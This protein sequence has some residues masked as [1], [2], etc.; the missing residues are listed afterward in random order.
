MILQAH[1][2]IVAKSRLHDFF[3]SEI[4][5]LMMFYKCVT[6]K[7]SVMNE[8]NGN[9]QMKIVFLCF[10]KKN[11]DLTLFIITNFRQDR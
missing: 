11:V 4:K 3:L 10:V 6:Y 9:L 8:A 7:M 5:K 1:I 2:V